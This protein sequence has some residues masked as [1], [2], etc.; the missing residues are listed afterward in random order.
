MAHAHDTAKIPPH[1]PGYERE[2]ARTRDRQ[3]SEMFD[4]YM[5]ASPS[6]R[7]SVTDPL[8]AP[9]FKVQRTMDVESIEVEYLPADALPFALPVGELTGMD[10][11]TGSGKTTLACKLIADVSRAGLNVLH[12]SNE[13][14]LGVM[15]DRIRLSG[16]NMDHVYNIEDPHSFHP[17]EHVEQ[18]G[19]LVKNHDIRLLVVEPAKVFS[20]GA[21]DA[22]NENDV[23]EKVDKLRLACEQ[24]GCTALLIHHQRKNANSKADIDNVSGSFAWSALA[25]VQ[26]SIEGD[27]TAEARKATFTKHRH[28]SIAEC[29]DAHFKIIEAW[30][31][32][33]LRTG[34]GV[35]EW[36]EAPPRQPSVNDWI[37]SLVTE[38]HSITRKDLLYQAS[39]DDVGS[40]ATIDR[41]LTTLVRSK[42][43]TKSGSTAG[44]VYTLPE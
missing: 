40:S 23:R 25:S 12:W 10:G 16:A 37:V 39:C 11:R 6:V 24:T 14:R 32:D 44:V 17:A 1:I 3:L 38:R 43:I 27:A 42:T 2:D 22:Y 41:A 8:G 13:M 36:V 28:K 15:R 33:G 34:V 26:I 18:L 9:A 4:R 20:A 30:E 21:R 19:L 31:P 5:A 29:H 35:I 7:I